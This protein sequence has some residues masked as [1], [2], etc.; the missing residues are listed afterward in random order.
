MLFIQYV[1]TLIICFPSISLSFFVFPGRHISCPGTGLAV[2]LL[3][4]PEALRY[5]GLYEPAVHLSFLKHDLIVDSDFSKLN[6]VWYKQY[7]LSLS[8]VNS[9][10][11]EHVRSIYECISVLWSLLQSSLFRDR[12]FKTRGQSALNVLQNVLK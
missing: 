3:A 8:V 12:Y 9:D 1:P 11:A 4:S 6:N 10:S 5:S 2:L 7:L